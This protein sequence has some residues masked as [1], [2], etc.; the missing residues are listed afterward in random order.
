L[1][2]QRIGD[3]IKLRWQDVTEDGL[4]FVQGK[5]GGR[6]RLLVEWSPA[7][8]AAIDACAVDRQRIGHVL[9]TQ[10][11]GSYTYGGIRSAWVRAC[12]RAGVADLNIHDL[13]GRAGVDALEAAGQDV[14][15]AQALLG[16]S[17]EGMT[18]H[19]TDG[20]YAKRVKPAG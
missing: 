8:R 3:L 19:Y 11:G 13:R 1:T 17:A 20:K 9:K 12:A 6:V 14:R 16:H 5:A 7:L 18:R 15:A 4:V 10:S 2:G